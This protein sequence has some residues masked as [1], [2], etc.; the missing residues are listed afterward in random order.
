M[1][2]EE[3]V[4]RR[5]NKYILAVHL[6]HWFP[7]FSLI[8]KYCFNIW[9]WFSEYLKLKN[10]LRLLGLPYIYTYLFTHLNVHTYVLIFFN[11]CLCEVD[12]VKFIMLKLVRHTAIVYFYCRSTMNKTLYC[13][14]HFQ[15]LWK[16]F[17][18]YCWHCCFYLF[19]SKTSRQHYYNWQ[20]KLIIILM[21]YSLIK[22]NGFYL[23]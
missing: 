2:N 9:S 8:Q 13:G 3:T 5:I 17:D 7:L 15:W 14:G 21:M 1:R 23:Y 12:T 11:S 18:F 20:Q 6:G 10:A 19:F 4:N 22:L 16:M